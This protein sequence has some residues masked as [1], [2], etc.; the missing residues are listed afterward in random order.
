MVNEKALERDMRE[1]YAIDKS[2]KFTIAKD[3]ID[4]TLFLIQQESI[5]PHSRW[6][7]EDVMI[8]DGPNVWIA[9]EIETDFVPL[10]NDPLPIIVFYQIDLVH[11]VFMRICEIPCDISENPIMV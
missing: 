11:K 4:L 6:I 8:F 9:V 7:L 1:Y 3:I 5:P 2:S 10:R